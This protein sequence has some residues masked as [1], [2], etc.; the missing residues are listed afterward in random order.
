[1]G[2]A[3]PDG[4]SAEKPV[5]LCYIGIAIGNSVNVQKIMLTGNRNRIRWGSSSRALDFLRRE[6]L[7]G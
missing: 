4:G 5:G 7:S 3:G 2:I 6:L 1:T